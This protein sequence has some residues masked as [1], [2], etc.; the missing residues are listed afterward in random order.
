MDVHV[1]NRGLVSANSSSN[2]LGFTHPLLEPNLTEDD[3][4]NAI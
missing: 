1:L 2:L 3:E 4:C